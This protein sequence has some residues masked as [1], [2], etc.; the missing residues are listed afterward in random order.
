M[1]PSKHSFFFLLVWLFKINKNLD[2]SCDV[3]IES[4]KFPFI[5]VFTNYTDKPV[6]Q[7][8]VQIYSKQ[9]CQMIDSVEIGHLPFSQNP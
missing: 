4:E 8:F 2:S 6:C 7:W 3:H 1:Y 5:P 9:R